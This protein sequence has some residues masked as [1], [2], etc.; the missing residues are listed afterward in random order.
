MLAVDVIAV[1]ADDTSPHEQRD[2]EMTDPATLAVLKETIQSVGFE[3]HHYRGVDELAR[4]A[5][6]HKSDIVLA[7]YD[8]IGGLRY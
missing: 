3:A 4:N 5:E 1:G 6:K 2:L 7:I 8:P